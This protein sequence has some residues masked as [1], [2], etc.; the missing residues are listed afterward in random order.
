MNQPTAHST[1]LRG[2]RLQLARAAW[3][4]AVFSMILVF[5][6]SFPARIDQLRLDPYQLTPVLAQFGFK[7]D[8]FIFYSLILNSLLALTCLA[9][10]LLIFWR[11]SNDWMGL[12]VSVGLVSFLLILPVFA[13]LAENRP[14]WQKLIFLLRMLGVLLLMLIFYLF[15]DGRYVPAWGRFMAVVF[16]LGSLAWLTIP[17]LNMPDSPV[18]AR[19]PV[20]VLLLIWVICALGSGVLAQIYRYQRAAAPL[21]RQQTKWVL[22]GFA[23][24]FLGLFLITLPIIIFPSLQDPGLPNLIYLVLEIPIG[25]FCW[26]LFPV[27][28]GV[29]ILRY[30]LWDID[31]I[32]RRTLVYGALT[33]TLALIYFASV[34][35]LQELFETLAGQSQS[36]LALVISTLA[37]AALF[38]PL[39]RRIQNDIDRRF[40]RRRYDAEKTLATF[41]ASLRHEVDLEQISRSLLAVTAESMQPESVSL[42]L[43]PEAGKTPAVRPE[44][45][46]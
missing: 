14:E 43:K 34:L 42:W 25:I 7:L 1:K 37:I 21:Q 12:L 11:K 45:N 28:L 5:M 38:N 3:A 13:A 23:G 44:G 6:L 15:P 8:H 41:A 26:L 36:P 30:R 16:W 33:A 31:L 22:L 46:L 20:Q 18:D 27:S 35:L 2:T 17:G 10:A 39:R 32:I 40:Y 9:I 29:S 24:V 19:S 4:A